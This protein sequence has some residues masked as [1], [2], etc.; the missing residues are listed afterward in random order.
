MSFFFEFFLFPWVQREELLNNV[1]FQQS[2][3][4]TTRAWAG[5]CVHLDFSSG[6]LYSTFGVFNHDS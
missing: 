3:D 4:S 6:A 2:S 5:F 1:P